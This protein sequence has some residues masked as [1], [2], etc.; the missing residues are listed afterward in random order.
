MP[1]ENRTFLSCGR[2]YCQFKVSKINLCYCEIFEIFAIFETNDLIFLGEDG[3]V[4]FY[5]LRQK[6]HCDCVSSPVN[7]LII[8]K[9]IKNFVCLN[10]INNA[11]M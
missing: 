4:R 5:D 9:T 8:I 6:D 3:T 10:K 1:N 11:L 7:F 2:L